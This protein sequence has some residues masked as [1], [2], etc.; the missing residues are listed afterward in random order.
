MNITLDDIE[1]GIRVN[2]VLKDDGAKRLETVYDWES[3]SYQTARLVFVGIASERGYAMQDICHYL[4]MSYKDYLYKLGRYKSMLRN[5][6]GRMEAFKK[7]NKPLHLLFDKAGADALDLRVCRKVVLIN[8]FLALRLQ[9]K[10]LEFRETLP[11][12]VH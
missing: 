8:N 10:A 2:F 5:G 7:K 4:D 12:Y 3:N 11:N 9:R 6:T 1:A